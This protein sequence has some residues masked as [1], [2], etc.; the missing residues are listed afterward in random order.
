MEPKKRAKKGDPRET[1]HHPV[2]LAALAVLAG[3]QAYRSCC[4]SRSLIA[5]SKGDKTT[6]TDA[7]TLK[8]TGAVEEIESRSGTSLQLIHDSRV[9]V[10]QG[11]RSQIEEAVRLINEQT[12]VEVR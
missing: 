10:I 4:S 12:G 3:R 7:K 2:T 11:S 8:S 6:D 5:D 9:I 1:Y